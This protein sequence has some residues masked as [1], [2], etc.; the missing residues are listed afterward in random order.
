MAIDLNDK[1]TNNNDLTNSG[2]AEVTTSLPFAD[3]TIAVDL[4]S[5]ESDY[6]SIA[7]A[8]QTGLDLSTTGTLE[9]WFKFESTPA[10]YNYLI[11]KDD[12][13]SNRSY[14]LR[15]S[16]TDTQLEAGVNDGSNWDLYY[17]DWTP[18]PGTWYHLAVTIN[19]GNASAT[20]F[21]FFIDGSSV[22]NGT[23]LLSANITAIQNGTA[24]FSI[25]SDGAG[26]VGQLFDGVI[27]EVRIWND[28]RTVSEIN[29]NKSVELTGSEDNL[30]AYW[31][32]EPG[33]AVASSGSFYYISQ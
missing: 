25:G 20:T 15:Y 30:V 8:S 28:V 12:T 21:E 29:N 31:P 1:T 16:T 23:A 33:I 14:F 19:T 24:P 6:L 22:G 9:G 26:T 27:D 4:E 13:A 7:D 32:F 17:Y 2:A 11:A 10:G 18:T 5:T 3:S